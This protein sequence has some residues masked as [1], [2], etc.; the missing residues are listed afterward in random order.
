MKQTI[1]VT[2]CSSGVGK[3]TA[4]NFAK[5]GYNVIAT[6]RNPD[7]GDALRSVPGIYVQQ[8]DVTDILSIENALNA[9]IKQF[10]G[11]DILVN[12]A[13]IGVLGAFEAAEPALIQQQF[14]TN[15]FGVMRTIKAILPHFRSKNRGMIINISSGVGIIPIPMQSLYDS[16]KFAL[17]GFS[18]SLYYELASLGIAVK[19]ILPGAIKSNFFK[20]MITTGLG[21]YPAYESY[22]AK[23]LENVKKSNSKSGTEPS[24]IAEVIYRAATDQSSKLRYMAGIDI[25]LFSKVRMILPESMFMNIIKRTFEKA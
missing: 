4:L 10:G 2:G 11:I 8:M 13:G 5:H 14:D 12:N 22:Q 19:L 9:G 24:L 7:N 3:A 17:E 25:K 23:V 16:T 20:S 21:N 18:E 6:M 15:V 1:L